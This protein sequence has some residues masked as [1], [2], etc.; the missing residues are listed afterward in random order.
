LDPFDNLLELMLTK[1]HLVFHAAPH[2]TL[3][4]SAD[5][6]QQAF[7]APHNL[8]GALS[9]QLSWNY[10]HLSDLWVKEGW[11]SNSTAAIAKA[12]YGGYS[13]MHAAN[14]KVIVINTDLW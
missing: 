12:H 7:D 14:L 11:I 5:Q 9:T 8:P 6:Y 2:V 3:Y 4:V 13:V 1:P 10:N